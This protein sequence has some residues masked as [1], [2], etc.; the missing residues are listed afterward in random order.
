VR[1][2]EVRQSESG[3]SSAGVLRHH[4]LGSDAA[5]R[6][7]HRWGSIVEVEVL[8]APGLE[9]GTRLHVTVAAAAAMGLEAGQVAGGNRFRF[10]SAVRNARRTA[11]GGK[12]AFRHLGRQLPAGAAPTDRAG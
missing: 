1:L 4:A 3:S 12:E 5:Y 7:L 9:P 2:R 8:A 6:V 11:H 10:R